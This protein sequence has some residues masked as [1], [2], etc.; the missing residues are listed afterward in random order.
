MK[1]STF[2]L[3]QVYARDFDDVCYP[4]G[5]PVD[6]YQLA[7]DVERRTLRD[8]RD[9]DLIHTWIERVPASSAQP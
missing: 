6:S 9:H 5:E 2:E 7:L 1:S 4:I 8:D 3:W